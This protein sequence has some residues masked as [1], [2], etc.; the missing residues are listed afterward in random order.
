MSQV[1]QDLFALSTCIHQTYIEIGAWNPIKYN[2]TYLLEKNGWRGFSIEIDNISKKPLWDECK[3][4]SNKIYWNDALD[5]D[6]RLALKENRLD[7]HIGY[8]SCDIDPPENTFKALQYVVDCGV[9]FDC[10][11]FEHDFYQSTIDYN[12]I[13]TEY[14]LTK[15]YKVA[16]FDVYRRKKN[17]KNFFE[18]WY[19]HSSINFE[20]MSFD[21]WRKRFVL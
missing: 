20:P 12:A 16:V 10:I 9:T 5:F 6:Y 15:N 8:L 21:D 3:E 17:N 7:C 19:V 18:T 1:H 11:T 2:N 4:R 13:A 14:L